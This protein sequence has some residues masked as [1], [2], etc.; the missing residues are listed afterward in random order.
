VYLKSIGGSF[1]GLMRGELQNL[2]CDYT[3]KNAFP[4]SFQTGV[5]MYEELN[6]I[7]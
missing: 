2:A 1:Y 5:V 6:G 4:Q 7:Y 3:E